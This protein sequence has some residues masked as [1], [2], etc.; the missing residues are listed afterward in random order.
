MKLRTGGQALIKKETKKTGND[1]RTI[2][3]EEK[4]ITLEPFTT[5]A[6]HAQ[7]AGEMR[8]TLSENYHSV[9]VGVYISIPTAPTAEAVQEGTEWCFEKVTEFLNKEAQ[10]ARKALKQLAGRE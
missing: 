6:V 3:S 5:E 9:S 4:T 7:V 2:S 8:L 10:G 1:A